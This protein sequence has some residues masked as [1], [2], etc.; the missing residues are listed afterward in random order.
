ADGHFR[1]AP[2]AGGVGGALAEHPPRPRI[3]LA[4]DNA[5]MREYVRG[6]L[7]PLYEVT[8][9][10]DGEAALEAVRREKPALVLSDVMMPGLDGFGLVREL[11]AD[12]AVA[13][14]PIILLSARAGEESRIEGLEGGADDYLVKPFSARELLARVSA[15]LELARAR[16]AASAVLRESEERFRHMAD[17]A[18]VMIW[19]TEPDGQCTFLSKSWYEFTGQT[20]ETGLGLGWTEAIH[21]DDRERDAATFLSANERRRPFR[22]EYRLR[23][24]DGEYR[25]AIDA[26]APRLGA[27][28]SFQG[29]I[30]SVIDIS[31]RKDVEEA[32]RI[33]TLRLQQLSRTAL[34]IN[35]CHSVASVAEVITHEARSI[36]GAQQA[37]TRLNVEQDWARDL[38][39][40]TLPAEYVANA[41][42]PVPAAGVGLDTLVQSSGVPVRLSRAEVQQRVA[43]GSVPERGWLAVPLIGRDG[44]HIGLIQLIDRREGEFTEADEAILVQMAQMGAIAI[45]NARLYEGLRQQDRRK[46][47]FLAM[48][49]HELRNPLAPI[50]N[51]V[52]ILKE[53]QATPS[54]RER[55]RALIERQVEMLARLVDDL[56]DVSRVTRGK[57]RLDRAHTF[58]SDVVRHAVETT[59]PL[60]DSQGHRLEIRLPDEPLTVE[61]DLMR[62]GQVLANLLS[63]AAKYTEPGGLLTIDVRREG[64]E[65]VIWVR[66]NGAGMAPDILPHIFDLFTQADRSLDR[67]QGGLG[68]GLALTKKLVELHDGTITASSGG[69]G[70]GS[71]F[72]VALPLLIPHNAALAADASPSESTRVA[73]RVLIVEDNQDSADMLAMMLALAGHEVDVAHDGAAGVEMARSRRPDVVLLDIGLPRMSGYEVALE[74]R[75][76]R[77]SAAPLLVAMTGYGQA[78]DKQRATETGFDRHLTKPVA[79]EELLAVVLDA[80]LL[81]DH[82][83]VES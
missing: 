51:A 72:R 28:G 16:D 6:L 46:D 42:Y 76:D 34:T 14:T 7:D 45:E 11:R 80:P 31:E 71:E 60:I 83:G 67:S 1:A 78:E 40:S 69:E 13:S 2:A 81:A 73:R 24:Q 25:W 50:R 17:H 19:V 79:P 37:V 77:T 4:D 66:D 56:L 74:I 44:Q 59:Q 62:L 38:N 32:N 82:P 64:D 41:G 9:V 49:A 8:A 33:E 43:Q 39:P 63:N 15:H 57:I 58:L 65:G 27:D 35:S 26:A 48:L 68:I 22:L 52:Y 18:P 20:P 55:V 47:E 21:P 5:D 12:P 53:P 54:Q 29:Y 10:G 70:K 75:G 3:L 36:V 61:G 30:G 23:R